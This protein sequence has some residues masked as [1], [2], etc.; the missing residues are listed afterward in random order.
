MKSFEDQKEN[1]TK[2]EW[3]GKTITFML[4]AMAE[5]TV[6]ALNEHL[7]TDVKV[8]KVNDRTSTQSGTF[9]LKINIDDIETLERE[10]KRAKTNRL[11]W[12]GQNKIRIYEG[13]LHFSFNISTA[14][15][16][17]YKD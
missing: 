7:G 2:K 5:M 16:W 6:Q 13:K 12:L 4:A 8:M 14:V 11:E 3:F 1:Y 17:L 15:N 9:S 10:M